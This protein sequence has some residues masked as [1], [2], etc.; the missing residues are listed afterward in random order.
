LHTIRKTA[1]VSTVEYLHSLLFPD[2]DWESPDQGNVYWLV[3]DEDRKPVGFCS[4]RPSIERKDTVFLSRVALLPEARGN[5]LQRRMIRTRL[6][7]AR[8]EGYT[9]ALTYTWLTNIASQRSL[10]REGFMPYRP[11]WIWEGSIAFERSL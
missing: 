11:F 4:C 9:R 10:I 2:A 6:R 8:S 5:G 7:W 1:D 3:R